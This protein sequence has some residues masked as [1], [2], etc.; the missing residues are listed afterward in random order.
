MRVK[1]CIVCGKQIPDDAAVCSRCGFP[2]EQ[3]YFL[4]EKHCRAWQH[5]IVEPARLSWQRQEL[6]EICLILVIHVL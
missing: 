2:A 4:S 5:E 1:I 6:E 3:R